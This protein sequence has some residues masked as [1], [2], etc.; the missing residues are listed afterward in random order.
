MRNVRGEVVDVLESCEGV[1]VTVIGGT[2]GRVKLGRLMGSF[3]DYSGG[4]YEYQRLT[5]NGFGWAH[6][7]WLE[8]DPRTEMWLPSIGAVKSLIAW[9]SGEA[10]SN[11][12]GPTPGGLPGDKRSTS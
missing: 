4:G 11:P 1:K 6:V 7:D 8:L 2:G 10:N 9:A 5:D 12:P 3:E